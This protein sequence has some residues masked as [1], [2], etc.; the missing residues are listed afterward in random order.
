VTEQLPLLPVSSASVT[1][2]VIASQSLGFDTV[3][4]P[5]TCQ[6]LS[7]ELPCFTVTV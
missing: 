1:S 4:F 3:M 5:E 2:A 6:A 7:L